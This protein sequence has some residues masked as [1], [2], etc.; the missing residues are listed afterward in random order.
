VPEVNPTSRP[1]FVRAIGSAI[2]CAVLFALVPG[3]GKPSQAAP[4]PPGKVTVSRPIERQ[5]IQWDEYAGNLSAPDMA[6]VSARVSGLIERASFQEGAIVHKGDVL[7]QIDPRPFQADVDAKQAAVAQAQAQADQAAIHLKRYTEVRGTK[8]ISA[9]DY[10]TARASNEVA[11]A[12]LAAAKAALESSDLNLQWTKVTAPITGR[13]SRMNVQPGNLI[14][15]GG[16]NSGGGSGGGGGQPTQLTTIVS[17]DPIYCYVQVPEAAAIRYQKLSLKQKGADIAHARIPCYL[18][19]SGETGFPHAGVIDFI[20][21]QVDTGTGTVTIRG[22]FANPTRVLTPGMFA[23]LRV[24]GTERYTAMLIPDAAI[25]AN[26]NERFVLLV[27]GDDVVHQRP[28]VMGPMFGNLRQIDDGLKLSDLV[29]VNGVQKARPGA[30]VEPHEAPVPTESLDALQ[31]TDRNVPPLTPS[32]GT[33]GEGRGGGSPG[34]ASSDRP[35]PTPPPEYR[36]RENRAPNVPA[37][38]PSTE[39]AVLQPVQIPPVTSRPGAAGEAR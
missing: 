18:Q 38:Q 24:P 11:Q 27:D 12:G 29:V 21:N 31:T 16:G 30:K 3:C 37:T 17:I 4:P 35:L 14:T 28:V 36:G 9:E 25:N 10:D 34:Q 26:Q 33:P 20:D 22:V 23:R 15:G 2:A 5:V 7:F 6:T 13:I 1:I 39:P 32:S 8:A 19:L